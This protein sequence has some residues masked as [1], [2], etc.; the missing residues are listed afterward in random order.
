MIIIME[1][2]VE[3]Q[4][5]INFLKNTGY[6]DE[7]FILIKK[8]PSI[9]FEMAFNYNLEEMFYFN[10]IHIIEE[11]IPYHLIENELFYKG[12][13][14]THWFGINRK[15]RVQFKHLTYGVSAVH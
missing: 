11:V 13:N 10:P 6:Y 12:E 3:Y 4:Q 5:F 15:W 7:F 8:C 2:K 14:Y 9:I 1:N